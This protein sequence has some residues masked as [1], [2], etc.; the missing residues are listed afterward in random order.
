MAVVGYNWGVTDEQA[1]LFADIRAA[2]NECLFVR[3]RKIGK[4]WMR[5]FALGG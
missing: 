3:D 1:F 4:R 2:S 5:L